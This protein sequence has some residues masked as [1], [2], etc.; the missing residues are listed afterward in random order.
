MHSFRSA[1]RL[2]GIDRAGLPTVVKLLG[3]TPQPN[4]FNRGGVLTD[5]DVA[6][7]RQVIEDAEAG[8]PIP[9]KRRRKPAKLAG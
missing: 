7:I 5:A 9:V 8:N 3:I 4:P 2:L 1:A 6:L